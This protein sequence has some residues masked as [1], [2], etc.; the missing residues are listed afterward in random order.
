M[1][2]F[3]N[4]NLR[5]H[6]EGEMLYGRDIQNLC[7]LVEVALVWAG[8]DIETEHAPYGIAINTPIGGKYQTFLNRRY[9]EQFELTDQTERLLRASLAPLFFAVKA[10]DKET[11][12]TPDNMA[13]RDFDYMIREISQSFRRPWVP[14]RQLDKSLYYDDLSE[15]ILD[16]YGDKILPAIE[17]KTSN[18]VDFIFSLAAVLAAFLQPESRTVLDD[19]L[20]RAKDVIDAWIGKFQQPSKKRVISVPI[21]PKS[22][23]RTITKFNTVEIKVHSDGSYELRLERYVYGHGKG[24]R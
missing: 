3:G 13:D 1:T 5:V 9:S 17:V 11:H 2:H 16:H 19:I 6:V 24:G 14:D 15:F 4:Q 22:V 7:S 18:S 20:R 21:L 23:E 10:R 8:L 12:I